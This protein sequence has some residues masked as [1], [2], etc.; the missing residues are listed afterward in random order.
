MLYSLVTLGQ[1]Q[2]YEQL[3]NRNLHMEL[4]FVEMVT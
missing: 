4:F 2:N 1:K 3:S